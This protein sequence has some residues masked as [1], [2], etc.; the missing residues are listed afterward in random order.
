MDEGTPA[1]M[2]WLRRKWLMFRLWRLEGMVAHYYDTKNE[3]WAETI[4]EYDRLY[5][6]LNAVDA[7]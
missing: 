2:T 6:Q 1:G 4:V 7:K 5:R 3:R